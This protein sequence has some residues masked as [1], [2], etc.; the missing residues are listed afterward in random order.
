M[1]KNKKYINVLLIGPISPPVTGCS[2]VNDLVLEKLNQEENFNVTIINRAYPEFNEAIGEFSFKKVFFYFSQYFQ[3]VK[4]FKADI[5]YIAI[6]LTFF[7]VLKDAPFVFIS[8][9]LGKQVVIHVHG[10]YL[11]MQYALLSGFKKKLFHY[12]LSRAN[13]G[14]VSSE[15]LKDNLTPFLAQD[16][17]FWMPYFVEKTLK[18]ITEEDAVNTNGLNILWLSNLMEGKGIFDVFEAL[19]I[20]NSKGVPYKAKIVGGIDEE[21]KDKI[22]NY[23]NS[24]PNIEYSKPIRG[25]EKVDVY[26]ISN[27]FILP[28]YYNMEGQPIALLEAMLTG[29]IIIT[30]DHA[31][32]LDICSDKNGY[33][34]NKR[35][36]EQ[37][38]EKLEYIF[39]NIKGFKDIMV[40]NHHYAKNTFRPE[41]FINRLA[42]ILKK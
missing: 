41:D 23:I 29:H 25:Q 42:D 6:G 18:N 28:T 34:V 30:T 37:I 33:I 8:K 7:G 16:K 19:N 39:S 22:L 13:K 2:V 27:V 14:I 26:K 21:Q 31:G 11:K 4:I 32:I 12:V 5:T 35:D 1:S 17:I 20:L 40:Y 3:A 24:N 38:A 15:L 10:N 36:P 9:L